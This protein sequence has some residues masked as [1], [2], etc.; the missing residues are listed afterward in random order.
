MFPWLTAGFKFGFWLA[1]PRWTGYDVASSGE[2]ARAFS[3][4]LCASNRIKIV[5]VNLPIPLFPYHCF[6]WG[7]LVNASFI[8]LCN[9][10]LIGSNGINVICQYHWLTPLKG[11]VYLHIRELYTLNFF[12]NYARWILGYTKSITVIDLYLWCN[13]CF[14]DL[15]CN[16]VLRHFWHP[17]QCW[18]VLEWV[19]NMEWV[20]HRK[21]NAH[22]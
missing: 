18:E 3:G 7:L 1:G 20:F 10:Y 13:V 9:K 14:P 4:A 17:S 12:A 19:K 15:T 11:Y 8:N 6:L 16:L 21:W 22:T 5:R 2:N